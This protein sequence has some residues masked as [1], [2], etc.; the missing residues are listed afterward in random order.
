M[1][2][3]HGIS[4]KN[5]HIHGH[6]EVDGIRRKWEQDIVAETHTNQSVNVCSKFWKMFTIPTG[7]EMIASWNAHRTVR[8]KAPSGDQHCP[9]DWVRAA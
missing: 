4:A 1:H 2:Q 6:F 8:Q 7:K 3:I 5:H 9:S